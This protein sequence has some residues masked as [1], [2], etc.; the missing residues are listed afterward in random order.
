MKNEITVT[1]NEAQAAVAALA[2]VGQT[3]WNTKDDAGVERVPNAEEVAEK[4]QGLIEMMKPTTL[5]MASGR[6]V[7]YRQAETEELLLFVDVTNR[8]WEENNDA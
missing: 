1:D 6:L 4:Y 7:V 2:V 3:W 8:R 5:M